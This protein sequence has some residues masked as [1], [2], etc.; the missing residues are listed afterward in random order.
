MADK[1][2]ATIYRMVLPDHTCPYGVKAADLLAAHGY[3]VD[4]RLLKSR[5][6]VDAFKEREEVGTT[7]QIFIGG[8]RIGGCDDL[9]RFLGADQAG[10]GRA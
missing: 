4:D 1:P 3:A 6:E 5:E 8:R 2:A 9:E 7:P 10:R